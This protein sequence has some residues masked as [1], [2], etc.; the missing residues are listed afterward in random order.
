MGSRSV[1]EGHT[2]RLALLLRKRRR[3]MHAAE[4]NL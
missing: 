4:G 1:K 3:V 2:G